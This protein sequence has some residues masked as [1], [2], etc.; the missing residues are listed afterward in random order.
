M[1]AYGWVGNVAWI[2]LS[3]RSIRIEPIDKYREWIGGRG[4]ASH[5]LLENVPVEADPFSAENIV[6][7]S[8]G[9]LTGTLSPASG[10]LSI[11]SKNALTHGYG[12][13]NVGGY[14]A[15]EL[16][17][18]GFDALVIRGVAKAPVYL[19]IHDGKIEICSA[20]G[21]WGLTTS[22]CD[23]A[24][25][26]QS[27]N[28]EAR[29]LCIGPGGE[30]L[31]K[32]AN[33]IVDKGRSASYGG[34][35]A[36]LG[37]KRLKAIVVRGSMSIRVHSPDEFLSLAREAFE[38]IDRSGVVAHLKTYGLLAASPPGIDGRA[39]HV[40]RNYK[41]G[42]WDGDKTVKTNPLV[43]I[44]GHGVKNLTCYNCPI[45]CSRLFRYA[46]EDGTN[47]LFEG[48]QANHI[49]NFGSMIDNDDP[50]LIL[51]ASALCNDLGLDVDGCGC[52]IA[53]AFES[54]ERGKLSSSQCDGLKMN[55]GNRGAVIALLHQIAQRK[56]LGDLLADGPREAA[57]RLD[58]ETI[59]W[60]M[61][62]KGAPLREINMQTNMSWALGVAVSTRG[63]GH[64]NGAF[65]MENLPE[66]SSEERKS[67]GFHTRPDEAGT[68]A[69]G[70]GVAWYE[71]FKSLVDSLGV[72]Y[73]TT[74]WINGKALGPS[75]LAGLYRAATGECVEARELLR[76]GA[77]VQNIEKAF[78][79]LHAGMGRESDFPPS[80]LFEK[81]I[82][83]G[84]NMGALLT[85]DRWNALL[86]GYYTA[87][88]Y[89]LR[90]GWQTREC[91]T[92]CGLEAVARRLEGAGR[93]I[94]PSHES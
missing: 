8:T 32:L 46:D 52:S 63:S 48:F 50:E 74:W 19:S 75:D 51:E 6:V 61:S 66:L 26:E 40:V 88:K 72:C 12:S 76:R 70:L 55:W 81:P 38:K 36:I 80:R 89:D 1:P 34:I 5:L 65:R 68:S 58:R 29:V 47:K 84:V 42:V 73:F 10:R 87:R 82:S 21:L 17:R 11:S 57:G 7:I 54:F 45:R 53:W 60:A 16:K 62:I 31:C 85:R 56:G 28:M 83:R 67:V 77:R 35:G 86:D 93:L 78:N 39:A 79:T 18:A 20:D 94:D 25:K 43:F 92:D 30:N 37:A 91:L 33:V 3:D 4:L 24:L 69:I 49:T 44:V 27:R 14:F 64:L 41:D 2:D 90:S 23:E 13:A 59:G 71:D 9:P 22:R 15:P